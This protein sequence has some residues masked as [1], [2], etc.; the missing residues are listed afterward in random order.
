M[1]IPRPLLAHPLLPVLLLVTPAVLVGCTGTA[2]SGPETPAGSPSATAS[3]SPAGAGDPTASPT[4]T[5][6]TLAGTPMVEGT[7]TTA[8]TPTAAPVNWNSGGRGTPAMAAGLPSPTDWYAAAF[9]SPTEQKVLYL[10]FDDGPA[11][12]TEALLAELK[13][14]G[15]KATFF[16]LGQ[17]AAENP[18]ML[19]RIVADG[20][21]IGNHSWDHPELTSLTAEEVAGQLSRTTAAVD[22]AVPGR[23]GGCMRP[24]YGLIDDQVAAVALSQHLQPILWTAHA[25]DW[26]QPSVPSMVADL[27][28]ATRPGAVILLHDGGGSRQNTL[29]AVA[30][31]LPEWRSQGYTLSPIPV[32]LRSPS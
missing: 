32:C 23:M 2:G 31:M 27:R 24:P 1:R 18:S 11:R 28:D 20:H 14:A 8:E 10:T 12:D 5:T 13:A 16:V 7:P 26:N 3:G 9:G 21:A 19:R 22:S 17:Q 4:A 29:D 25:E 15:A 6:S 30:A